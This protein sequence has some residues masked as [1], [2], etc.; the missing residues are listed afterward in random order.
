MNEALEKY[1]NNPED[2]VVL[3][4]S[5][6]LSRW[7]LR[8]HAK[9]MLER[10][11][12][13]PQRKSVVSENGLYSPLFYSDDAKQIT[14]AANRYISAPA[15]I[16]S[17]FG[18]LIGSAGVIT[19]IFMTGLG[20]YST[21]EILPGYVTSPLVLF[22]LSVWLAR[23]RLY[24]KVANRMKSAAVD[25]F[26][27]WAEERY[28]IKIDRNKLNVDTWLTTGVEPDN[29]YGIK[30]EKTG[31]VYGVKVYKDGQI[32]LRLVYKNTVI[33]EANTVTQKQ[34]IA[35]RK[36]IVEEVLPSLPDE[37]AALY[38]HLGSSIAL[39]RKQELSV[40]EEHAVK[41]TEQTVDTMVKQYHH[42]V[43]LAPSEALQQDLVEFFQTQ[44]VFLDG[45]KQEHADRIVKRM[46]VE[47][48]AVKEATVVKDVQLTIPR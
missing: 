29:S 48:V 21:E 15:I 44:V 4:T 35:Q 3:A 5:S 10:N 19:T 6:K 9:M 1:E 32:Y 14:E 20:G 8:K 36:E 7:Q 37:A 24:R 27:D 16:G 33:A 42:A 31:D 25:H 18:S 41:R 43:S 30:D 38:N 12:L 17:V 26:A 45:L 46:S 22:P 11:T 34:E 39:L 47:M 23:P 40:E 2:G 28:G 13:P